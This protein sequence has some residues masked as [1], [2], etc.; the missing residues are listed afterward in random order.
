MILPEVLRPFLMFS[1]LFVNVVLYIKI[2]SGE[3]LH[4]WIS[5]RKWNN[6][7]GRSSSGAVFSRGKQEIIRH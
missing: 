3:T 7:K 6:V 4:A 5:R 2:C 1:L